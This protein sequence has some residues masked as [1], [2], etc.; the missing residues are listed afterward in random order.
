MSKVT[1]IN[2]YSW[3]GGQRGLGKAPYFHNKPFEGNEEKGWEIAK[4]FVSNYS[5]D[6]MLKVNG[7]NMTIFVSKEGFGQS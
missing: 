3:Y 4:E 1:K 7:P 6:I 2:V 5:F